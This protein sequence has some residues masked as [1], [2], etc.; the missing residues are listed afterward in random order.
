[1]RLT[2]LMAALLLVCAFAFHSRA[3]VVGVDLEEVTVHSGFVGASDLTGFTTYRLYANCTNENDFISA[4]SGLNTTPMNITSTGVFF[5]NV[6]GASKGSDINPALVAVFPDVAFDSWV[7]IGRELSS[8]PGGDITIVTSANDEWETSFNA[9][10]PIEIDGDIGGSWFTLFNPSSV[11]GFAG[12]DLRVLLGQF[13]TDGVLSGSINVQCFF[14]GDNGN[15]QRFNGAVFSSDSNAVFGCTDPAAQ[16]YDPAA[17][18]DDGSCSFPCALQ[19]ENVIQTPPACVGDQNGALEVIVSG[20]QGALFYQLDNGNQLVVNSFGSLGAGSY[21]ITVTDGQG[22]TDNQVVDLLDPAPID[23]SDLNTSGVLCNG[24]SNGSVQIN[25]TGGTGGL[26]YSLNG[27]SFEMNNGL[28][29]N[30]TGGTY[31]IDVVDD[32][33]CLATSGNF[34]VSQPTAYSVT[35][36]GTSNATCADSQDGLISIFSFGGTAPYQYSIDGGQSFTTNPVISLEPGTYTLLAQD[37]NSCIDP[38]PPGSFTIAFDGILG[39]TDPNADNYNENADCDDGSCQTFGCTDPTA[40]NYDATATVDDG[41]CILLDDASF[42][43]S[44]ASYC[45]D[46]ADPTPTITGLGG[47]EFTSSPAGLN[48]NPSTGSI[49]VSTSTPGAY[50]VTYTSTGTCP[51]S[52]NVSVTINALDDTSFNYSAASYCAD[53]ADPT[54][55]ITGLG[56]GGFTSSPAGLNINPSTGSIDVST[57]TPGAY[58]VTYTSTG[59]CPNS[60]N[61]AITVSGLD[62]CGNC[63]GTDTTG[64]TDSGACNYDAAADCDDGTCEFLTCAGCTDATACNYD[65]TATIDDGS[66]TVDDACG[67]CGGTDTT[68]CTDSEACNYDSEADCDDNSC[69]YP[70]PGLDCSGDCINDCDGDGVCDEDEIEGC[71]YAFA[72]NFDSNATDDDGSCEIDSCSGCAYVSAINYDPNVT[73]DDGSCEFILDTDCPGDFNGDGVVGGTDLMIFLSVYSTECN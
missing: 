44:A 56:G 2:K 57:S 58:T 72:C 12:P 49:D 37:A 10:G 41:S 34:I 66:C 42:S 55:T 18:E 33:G 5:Q 68:G 32:N 6:F 22:C 28:F 11:N 4:I 65:A 15:D 46:D 7:T 71:T 13:T 63:G 30:L 54:P 21:D 20:E 35:I 24:D 19:I 31:F 53:D 3:Q 27:G 52:S 23:L 64:C 50:T 39:C 61:V 25:A 9:G 73:Y 26:S 43:Y 16:N 40:C 48:I 69:E 47:G 17:T 51:S 36:N 1:M 70:E 60:S 67:N 62:E 59:T 29:D 45:V 8:D 38:T 14:L